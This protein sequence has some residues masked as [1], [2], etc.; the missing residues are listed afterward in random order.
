MSE[1]GFGDG[2]AQSLPL[3]LLSGSHCLSMS[4]SIAPFHTHALS[5]SLSLLLTSLF[6]AVKAW[7]RTERPTL[8]G[9]LVHK[10]THTPLGPP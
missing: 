2:C 7:I 9:Y 8:Q 6:P 1:A 10:K 4:L 3:R 5:L